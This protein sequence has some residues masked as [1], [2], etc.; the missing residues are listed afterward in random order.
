[1]RIVAGTYEGFCY[2]WESPPEAALD[3]GLD[4]E[5]ASVGS[6]TK[7][8]RG[9]K[10][11][12]P[13][14]TTPAAAA[15]A[16]PQ[17]LSLVFGY[18]VHVGCMKSVAM[19]TSGTRAGQLLVTGGAD[20][21]VRIYDLRDRTEL[22]EL[23]QHNGT[24]TCMEFY[25]STHLLTGSEDNTVCI[26]RVHDWA[27]LHVLGGHKAAVTSLSIH[28]SGRMALSVSRDR[29]LRL[30]NLL[31][32]RCA[33]IKRL[34]GEGELVRWS[35]SGDRY[36]VVVSNTAVVYSAATSEPVG[37]CKHEARVNSACFAGDGGAVATCDDEKTIRL[38]RTEGGT[39]V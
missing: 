30:W 22:G 26:W 18:N 27:L 17:P 8:I 6:A 5:A 19:A 20:E 35:P 31:E 39:L 33:Y 24:I 4:K 15:A 32:G 13:S 11:S 16:A 21:R 3:R 14:S 23:Q 28:P 29:T 38:F 34:Q 10:P 12:Q 37:E 9:L 25:K 2:G 7:S 36:L 1:M